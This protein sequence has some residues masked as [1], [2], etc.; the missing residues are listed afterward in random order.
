M[1]TGK[2]EFPVTLQPRLYEAATKLRMTILTKL[3]DVQPNK[4]ARKPVSQPSEE[5]LTKVTGMHNEVS[6]S[7]PP[8][9]DTNQV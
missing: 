9:V 2:L 1:Y 8:T 6:L 7:T 5:S 4:A 3:L